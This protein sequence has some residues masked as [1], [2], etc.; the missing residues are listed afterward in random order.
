M[1]IMNVITLVYDP[2]VANI[3]CLPAL[4]FLVDNERKN[5]INWKGKSIVTNVIRNPKESCKATALVKGLMVP[6]RHQIIRTTIAKFLI[7][8]LA[9]HLFV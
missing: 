2:I 8:F 6:N 9:I 3:I 1:F 4:I 7:T 5:R